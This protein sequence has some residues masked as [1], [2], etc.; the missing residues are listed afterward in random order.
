MQLRRQGHG[1][2]E[3]AAVPKCVDIQ[4]CKITF[5]C[6]GLGN[7]V[8]VVKPKVETSWENSSWEVLL[9]AHIAPGGCC[10]SG[11]DIMQGF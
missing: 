5:P 4:K 10:K 6:D 2:A 1:Q 7:R 8:A 11:L 9:H 3:G